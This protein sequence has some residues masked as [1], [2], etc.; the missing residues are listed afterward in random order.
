MEGRGRWR[1]PFSIAPFFLLRREESCKQA[2]AGKPLE[3]EVWFPDLL[4]RQSVWG[5][6]D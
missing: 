6:S 2:R 1:R 5:S 4:Q 3:Q